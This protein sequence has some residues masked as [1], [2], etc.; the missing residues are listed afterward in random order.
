[1]RKKVSFDFDGTLSDH[2]QGKHNPNKE[3]IQKLFK[4]LSDDDNFDVYLITRR[5]GPEHKDKGL[6]CEHEG[7]YNL[8]D[9][10]NIVLPKEKLIFTN[11]EM[12]YYT[13]VNLGI[14]I[15]LD[16]EFRDRELINKF[17]KGSAVDATQSNWRQKFDELL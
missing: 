11:R 4:Q 15:H 17:T 9:E 3:G 7:V 1:M 2:F 8:L 16:D 12:K 13:V 5:Y 6:G 10:L 14:D